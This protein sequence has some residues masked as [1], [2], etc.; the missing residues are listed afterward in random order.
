MIAVG[1][2]YG[3]LTVVDLFVDQ[4]NRYKCRCICDCG[5]EIIVFQ[6]NL[7]RGHTQ[8]CGCLKT[9]IIADGANTKHGYSKTRLYRIWKYMRKRCRNPNDSNF[10]KYGA[11]GICVCKEWDDSFLLFREWAISNGYNDSLSL[12]RINNDG[13]YEPNNCRWASAK[14][15]GNNR[16]STRYLELN[17]IKKTL[18]EWSETTGLSR[19]VISARLRLGWSIERALTQP[20][21]PK[22]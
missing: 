8:S 1:E 7:P 3:R 2:R 18:E 6:S 13:N 10:H 14:T 12:D 16:R 21:R 19:S 11:R 9:E 17:G 22:Y 4:G 5:N 20:A 15:Q